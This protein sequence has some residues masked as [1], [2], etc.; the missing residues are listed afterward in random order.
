MAEIFR[1][2]DG[3]VLEELVAHAEVVQDRLD[4]HA[5]DIAVRAEETLIEHR[6]EGHAAIEVSE[7]DIDKYV[8]LND[9]A[10]DEAAMSIEYGRAGYID[11]ETGAAWGQMDGLYVITD[12]AG[13]ARKSGPRQAVIR[14]K[15]GPPGRKRRRASGGSS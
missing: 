7:G 11:P 9:E 15:M 3:M 12:A 8:W 10:G 6:L 4:F 13:L 5:F 1:R 14:K 2:V